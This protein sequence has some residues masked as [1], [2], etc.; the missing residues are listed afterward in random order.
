MPPGNARKVL[1]QSWLARPHRAMATQLLA[2]QMTAQRL[3]ATMSKRWWSRVRSTRGSCRAAKWC[4]MES[5]MGVSTRTSVPGWGDAG[6]RCGRQPRSQATFRSLPSL[7]RLPWLGAPLLLLLVRLL[8]G[9]SVGGEY[10]GSMS[11]LA[12]SAQPGRRGFD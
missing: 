1:S 8:Q 6:H 10:V 3:I 7:M 11:Y 9:L 4:R 2:P 5:G 12:E